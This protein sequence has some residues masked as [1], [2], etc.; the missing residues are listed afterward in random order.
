MNLACNNFCYGCSKLH[1]PFPPPVLHLFVGII[2]QGILVMYL[3]NHLFI[4]LWTHEYLLDSLRYSSMLSLLCALLLNCFNHGHRDLY[5]FSSCILLTCVHPSLPF[6][7]SYPHPSLLPSFLPTFFPAFPSFLPLFLPSCLPFFFSFLSIVLL[8]ATTKCSRF[9]L[10][11]PCPEL[12]WF[13]KQGVAGQEASLERSPL[14]GMMGVERV[15]ALWWPSW[16]WWGWSQAWGS[17]E[18]LE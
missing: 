11:F 3:F 12:A 10:Y 17:Q 2:L 5:Q 9:I 16:G 7:P 4:S 6:L 18:Q 8:Q 14:Q 15:W 13:L 1:F